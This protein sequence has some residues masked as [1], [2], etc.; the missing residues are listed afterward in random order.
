MKSKQE[1]ITKNDSKEFNFFYQKSVDKINFWKK[2]TFELARYF[3]EMYKNNNK[4]YKRV[5]SKLVADKILDN[6]TIKYFAYIGETRN[7]FLLNHQKKLPMSVSTLKV[8][9]DV[10]ETEKGYI[11]LKDDLKKISLENYNSR[12]IQEKYKKYLKKNFKVD[13][14]VTITRPNAKNFEDVSRLKNIKNPT[15]AINISQK[16]LET[17]PKKVA[18]DFRM[19]Q[20]MFQY[21]DITIDKRM[22]DLMLDDD[23]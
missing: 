9:R 14:K 8:I 3:S 11:Q 21:A 2:N 15:I 5:K 16:I 19:I 23:K 17:S 7:G 18:S 20:R 10:A 1:L 22:S 6:T 4:V 12:D 13:K